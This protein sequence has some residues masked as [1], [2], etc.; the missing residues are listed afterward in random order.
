MFFLLAES[1][2][3][4]HHKPNQFRLSFRT[5][6]LRNQLTKQRCNASNFRYFSMVLEKF[7]GIGFLPEQGRRIRSLTQC[8]VRKIVDQAP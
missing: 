8:G 2:P 7:P 3:D 5:A 4:S 1:N 6:A